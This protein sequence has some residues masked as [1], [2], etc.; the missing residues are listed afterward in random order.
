M[1]KM[2]KEYSE[3]FSGPIVGQK[4]QN[5]NGDTPTVWLQAGAE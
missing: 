2:F 5:L 1:T 4:T 3:N